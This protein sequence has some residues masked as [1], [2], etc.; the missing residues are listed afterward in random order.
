MGPG[1]PPRARDAVLGDPAGTGQK[2]PFSQY[3]MSREMAKHCRGRIASIRGIRCAE[4]LNRYAAVAQKR[5]N[6]WLSK[7][8]HPATVACHPIYDWTENDVFK[9]LGENGIRYCPLYDS[10]L[11]SRTPCRVSTPIHSGSEKRLDAWRTHGPG[12][13]PACDGGL[14]RHVASGALFRTTQPGARTASKPSS[15][16]S[17]RTSPMP[18]NRWPTRH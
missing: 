18:T 5:H 2:G 1:P 4:S 12:F 14:S 10:Q 6:C 3:T 7:T 13:S 16:G 17:R 15:N 8:E 9:Y 11:Y